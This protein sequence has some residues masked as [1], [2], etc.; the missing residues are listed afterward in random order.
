VLV[1]ETR[2]TEADGLWLFDALERSFSNIASLEGNESLEGLAFDSDSVFVAAHGDGEPHGTLYSFARTALTAETPQVVEL[3]VVS[4][5]AP[6]FDC[7]GMHA[8]ALFACV[9]D[10][11]RDSEWLLAVS[12]DGGESWAPLLQLADLLQLEACPACDVT[13]DWL[14]DTY[15][16]V[17]TPAA[18]DAGADASTPARAPVP[19]GGCKVSGF[20]GVSTHSNAWS[21]AMLGLALFARRRRRMVRLVR[22]RSA[23]ML[24]TVLRLLALFAAP[25]ACSSNDAPP[26]E[27]TA[28]EDVNDD[29]SSCQGR[30]FRAPVGESVLS[31]DGA[32]RF[33]VLEATPTTPSVGANSWLVELD[34]D[35]ED[36]VTLTEEDITV[37]P[38][39]PDHGH[40][41][42]SAVLVHEVEEGGLRL[43]PITLFMPG[44][45]NVT[46]NIQGQGLDDVITIPVCVE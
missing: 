38:F 26:G 30:G 27:T 1:L 9:N 19:S 32:I 46:L 45:W 35:S 20:F 24:R 41:S 36:A 3:D 40:G 18:G 10:F 25:I 16:S 33:E 23:P 21:A 13:Q 43:E 15:G 31:L 44:L 22:S 5:T 34:I 11:S 28:G 7:L 42:P 39:M 17:A 12:D 8:G 14:R 29:E 37:T 6:P 2:P 4:D